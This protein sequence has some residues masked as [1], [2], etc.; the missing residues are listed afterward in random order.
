MIS[1]LLAS[2]DWAAASTV[3]LAA[4]AAVAL[5]REFLHGRARRK[6]IDAEISVLAFGLR[7]QMRSW[8]ESAITHDAIQAIRWA[9]DL[10]A[11]FDRAEPKA[12]KIAAQAPRSS[13]QTAQLSSDVLRLFYTSTEYLNNLAAV[14]PERGRFSVVEGKLELILDEPATLQLARNG[15]SDIEACIH[16]LT[17]LLKGGILDDSAVLT[18]WNSPS[19]GRFRRLRLSL[20]ASLPEKK[21][22]RRNKRGD[23]N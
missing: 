23:G 3:A 14:Q 11:H 6:A 16:T 13:S 2:V 10:S 1:R 22:L 9:Q 15:C 21:V 5:G 18:T 7:R 20:L 8:L 12:T 4:V 19:M 17:K